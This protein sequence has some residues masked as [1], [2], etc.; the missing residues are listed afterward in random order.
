LFGNGYGIYYSVIS[1]IGM[2]RDHCRNLV[3]MPSYFFISIFLII[4]CS[5]SSSSSQYSQ[6]LQFCYRYPLHTAIVSAIHAISV[7]P[8]CSSSSSQYSQVL[9]F[10]Y[11]YPL[12][13]AIVS[14]LHALSVHAR[15]ISLSA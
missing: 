7:L 8:A 5:C 14:A 12:H 3:I 6:I 11:R 13:T 9:Q 1:S 2:T 15:K 4:M 10:C